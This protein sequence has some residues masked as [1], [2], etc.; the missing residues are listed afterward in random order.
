M[1]FYIAVAKDFTKEALLRL[2]LA[3][4]IKQDEDLADIASRLR[5][6]QRELESKLNDCG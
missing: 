3:V 6:L 5:A 2:D 4:A 1:R